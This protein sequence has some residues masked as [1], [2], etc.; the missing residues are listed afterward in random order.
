MNVVSKVAVSVGCFISFSLA[1]CP[2]VVIIA[3]E[4]SEKTLG[5]EYRGKDVQYASVE[6]ANAVASSYEGSK[7]MTESELQVMSAT[8]KPE[9]IIRLRVSSFSLEPKFKTARYA[10]LNIEE[11]FYGAEDYT[12]LVKTVN[13]EITGPKWFGVNLP[14]KWAVRYFVKETAKESTAPVASPK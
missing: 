2:K 12:K 9:Q 4:F 10:I 1:D 11:T 7:I 5:L 8:C 6:V 13:Q 14:L 3:P